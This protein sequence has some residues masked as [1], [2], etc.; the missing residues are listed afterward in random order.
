MADFA[1]L[2]ELF[3]EGDPAR[4]RALLRAV[5]E[6]LLMDLKA[7]TGVDWGPQLEQR[8]YEILNSPSAEIEPPPLPSA[9][10]GPYR[11]PL[12]IACVRC[13]RKVPASETNVTEQG[14]VCDR[15]FA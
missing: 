4:T 7:R 15:C 8:C 14:S 1:W 5:A 6:R 3:A 10:A 11:A 12:P 2:D 9:D 13:G